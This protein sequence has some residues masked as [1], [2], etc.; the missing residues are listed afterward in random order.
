[1]EALPEGFQTR[2]RLRDILVG[3]I[4][5]GC[6]QVSSSRDELKQL[7]QLYLQAIQRIPD[8]NTLGPIRRELERNEGQRTS[9]GLLLLNDTELETA[10]RLLN[11]FVPEQDGSVNVG[12]RQVLNIM[13]KRVQAT[14]ELLSLSRERRHDADEVAYVIRRQPGLPPVSLNVSELAGPA[15]IAAAGATGGITAD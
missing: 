13:L 5:T 15:I 7:D 14:P 3:L 11:V 1:M 9:F 4:E 8:D 10:F 12:R 2:Q 6:L